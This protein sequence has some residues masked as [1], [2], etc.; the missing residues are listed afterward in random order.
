MAAVGPCSCLYVCLYC[1]KSGVGGGKAG[2]GGR[3][4]AVGTTRGIGGRREATKR[5]N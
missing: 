5:S 2:V 3:E 1:A 4:D